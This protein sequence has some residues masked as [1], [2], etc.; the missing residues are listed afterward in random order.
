[1]QLREAEALGAFVPLTRP[2]NQTLAL[3][4]QLSTTQTAGT[5]SILV[6]KYLIPLNAENSGNNKQGHNKDAC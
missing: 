5:L 1:V 4:D 3:P 2:K 6:P